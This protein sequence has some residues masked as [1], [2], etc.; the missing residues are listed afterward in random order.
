[1]MGILGWPL[2][3]IYSAVVCIRNWCFD[4]GLLSI[5]KCQ[6]PVISIGNIT[7]GGTG[8]TPWVCLT[9]EKLLQQKY[10][11][12]VV[13]RG[14]GR[15]T[16]GL[17]E[18]DC[19]KWSALEVGD[20][21]YMM[22]S[23]YQVPV[24]VCASRK[25]AMAA[26]LKKYP[27]DV[28][29]LDDGFQHR[30]VHRDLN[31][32]LFD[33]SLEVEKYK[34]LPV[35]QMREPWKAIGRADV[36]IANKWSSATPGQKDFMG[37]QILKATHKRTHLISSY[38]LKEPVPIFDPPGRSFDKGQF[39]LA[40]A[41]ARPKHFLKTVKKHIGAPQQ[42]LY[43]KDHSPW[44]EL[45][46]SRLV[47]LA[48]KHSLSDILVTEKDAVKFAKHRTICDQEGLNIWFCPLEIEILESEDTGF[49]ISSEEQYG[50]QLTRVINENK[51]TSER[52]L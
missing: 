21:P 51:Q 52:V 32:V 9:L 38:R 25:K 14:Y 36:L 22:A 39:I 33:S 41:I 8:K 11:V 24:F 20:E 3:W 10:R 30:Y 18:V 31:V 35:G 2:Q 17:L 6:V 27:V 37:S 50:H 29:L 12:G 42:T 34:M 5:Y 43:L 45:E 7:T 13:S 4:R 49:P 23:R 40:C 47:H 44:G 1:M 16:K 28:I 48:K 19:K 15:S 46:C 26:L